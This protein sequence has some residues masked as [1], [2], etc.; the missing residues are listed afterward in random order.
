MESNFLTISVSLVRPAMVINIWLSDLSA[1]WLFDA[2]HWAEEIRTGESLIAFMISVPIAVLIVFAWYSLLLVLDNATKF[3][4]RETQRMGADKLTWFSFVSIPIQYWI[5]T[6]TLLVLLTAGINYLFGTD[7][8]LSISLC[9]LLVMVG[10][11]IVFTRK[12]IQYST[13]SDRQGLTRQS[14]IVNRP[15]DEKKTIRF[16]ACT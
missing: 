5:A 6:L 9:F 14:L 16:N 10:F 13:S 3:G 7:I 12:R 15:S 8:T 4:E 1:P 2:L 11:M